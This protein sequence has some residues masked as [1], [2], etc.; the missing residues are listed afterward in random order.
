MR[1]P[2][3]FDVYIDSLGHLG[4]ILKCQREQ[5]F[6]K[7]EKEGYVIQKASERESKTFTS[8]SEAQEAVLVMFDQ[9][10]APKKKKPSKKKA[11]K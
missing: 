2:Q 4:F 1:T 8:L 5:I 11:S 9:L 7:S 6:I 10:F 3:G